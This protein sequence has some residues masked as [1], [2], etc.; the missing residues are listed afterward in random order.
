MNETIQLRLWQ[1]GGTEKAYLMSTTPKDAHRDGKQV[2]IPRS[3]IEHV[4]R[5]P[6][7]VFEWQECVVTL[8]LWIAEQKGIC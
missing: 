6:A 8:P 3:Q 1:V 4:S 5:M 2:W 7:S